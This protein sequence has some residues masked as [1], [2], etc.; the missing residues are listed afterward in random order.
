MEK[1]MEH[2]IYITGGLW[3]EGKSRG[4]EEEE[5][6]CFLFTCPCFT[7]SDRSIM[8]HRSTWA[9]KEIGGPIVEGSG[10]QGKTSSVRK[11][12]NGLFASMGSRV[13]SLGLSSCFTKAV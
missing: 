9:S 11:R 2:S 12:L 1:F 5:K 3:A 8:Q 7:R 10:A 13:R 4:A 6:L